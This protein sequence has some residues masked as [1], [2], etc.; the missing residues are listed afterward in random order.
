MGAFSQVQ[1]THS[2][3]VS[4]RGFRL[5]Q[6][7]SG[8]KPHLSATPQQAARTAQPERSVR[9]NTADLSLAARQPI[10][11]AIP[12]NRQSQ[13]TS[14]ASLPQGASQPYPSASP[15]RQS[16]SSQVA[17]TL[18]SRR[19]V[20]SRSR[21][22]KRHLFGGFFFALLAIIAIL[23][24]LTLAIRETNNLANDSPAQAEHTTT[25]SDAVTSPFP[26]TVPAS[27]VFYTPKAAPFNASDLSP[28]WSASPGRF[29]YHRLT[30][31]QRGIYDVYY[32]ALSSGSL[33]CHVDIDSF[34]EDFNIVSGAVYLDNPELFW[35]KD[36]F[37]YTYWDEPGRGMDITFGSYYDL[38][39]IPA[40]QQQIE[41]RI[42]EF[43]VTV[44]LTATSYEKAQLAYVWLANQS[45]YEYCEHDQI[46]TSA[47]LEGHSVCAGYART[48]QVLLERM[49]IPCATLH[50]YNDSDPEE[51]HLWNI[52]SIG[53]VTGY[54]DVTWGDMDD[55]NVDPQYFFFN[56]KLL[57][58]IGH[59]IDADA[60]AKVPPCPYARHR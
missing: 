52:V 60:Q 14:P 36:Y 3:S 32:A 15:N 38:E 4:A 58:Q 41:A 25:E 2:A 28:D 33:E 46:I 20:L 50:G 22:G 9:I 5:T 59:H 53:G 27:T 23:L 34:D 31:R 10:P 26:S 16:Q 40:Y 44:P 8:P 39:S 29:W 17:P 57:E 42:E 37:N 12:Q 1:T 13:A 11:T 54:V 6:T 24:P 30:E 43:L 7:P 21:V 19:A 18:T 48:Y 45:V 49:G 47:L 35:Y 55:G 56:D 51:G